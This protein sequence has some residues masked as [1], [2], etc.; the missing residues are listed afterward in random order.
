MGVLEVPDPAGRRSAVLRS[1]EEEACPDLVDTTTVG[2][3]T[4]SD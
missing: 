1:G 2:S 4:G 3:I